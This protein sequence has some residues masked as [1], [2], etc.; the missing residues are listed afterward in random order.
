MLFTVDVAHNVEGIEDMSS[1]SRHGV[2]P[3]DRGGKGSDFRGGFVG[4]EV[5][6]AQV[7]DNLNVHDLPQVSSYFHMNFLISLRFHLI[8]LAEV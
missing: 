1:F 4:S 7:S 6:T 2:K 8:C 5:T 3:K